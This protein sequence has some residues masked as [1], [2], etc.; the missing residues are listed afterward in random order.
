MRSHTGL[1]VLAVAA[2]AAAIGAPAAYAVPIQGGGGGAIPQPAP[3]T[4]Q[5]AQSGS[6]DWAL[7]GGSAAGGLGILAVGLTAGH[8]V[9]RVRLAAKRV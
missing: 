9:R 6:T 7:I 4:A 5:N 2:T 3:V 8:R 1:H